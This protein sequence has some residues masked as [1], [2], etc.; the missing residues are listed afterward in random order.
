MRSSAATPSCIAATARRRRLPS[1]SP[2]TSSRAAARASRIAGPVAICARQRRQRGDLAA[3][4]R[5]AAGRHLGA[6]IPDQQVDGV[7]HIVQPAGFLGEA[8]IAHGRLPSAAAAR[9]RASAPGP[10]GGRRR[11]RSRSGAAAAPRPGSGRRRA[12]SADGTGSR[13]AG[14]PGSA[15]R[16][17]PPAT[18]RRR[19]GSRSGAA[20][21]SACGVGVPRRARTAPRSRPVS[22]MRAEIHHRDPVRDVADQAQIMRDEQH[23]EAEPLLQ[24]QQQVDDLR[25]HRDVEGGDQLVGDQAFRLHRQRPRDADALALAAGEFMRIAVGRHRAAAAPGPAAR[26]CAPAIWRLRAHAV[27]RQR[28]GQGLAHRHARVERA[29]GVLEHHLHAAVEARAAL[30]PVERPHVDA[31]DSDACP[32]SGSMQPDEA[33]REGGLAAAGFADDAER[34]AALDR[35]G[36]RRSAHAPIGLR[37]PAQ[38]VGQRSAASGKRL[39]QAGD[40]AGAARS[41]RV[42]VAAAHAIAGSDA[43]TACVRRR[44]ASSGG[45]S[46]RQAVGREARSAARRRSRAARSVRGGGAPAIERSGW[47]GPPPRGTESQQAERVGMARRARRPRRPAPVSTTRPAYI[48]ATRSQVCATTPRSWVT[49]ITLIAELVAQPQQQ[50]QDLVL[51]GDVERGGRLVGQQQ[52]RARGER[53][54]DHRA[55]PH[56]AGELVRIV[57]EPRGAAAGMPTRSSSSIARVAPRAG[58]ELGVRPRG[59]RR[60]AGRRAAPG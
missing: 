46:A 39:R 13:T 38:R 48:T 36:R 31:V 29:V 16:R 7:Q 21:S 26:R 53:D 25:L 34:L 8:V 5:G 56:A 50:L 51:D 45:R 41:C 18:R 24:L 10:A 20:A 40:L 14:R 58:A 52:L 57:V 11:C 49:R 33:A 44:S 37:P 9:L 47:R 54:G 30:G 2:A 60:S 22:T 4:R 59:S 28:L 19:P 32:R 43:G 35:R 27:H 17:A 6:G 55:L 15:A 42:T 12:G 3:A 23:G 1:G